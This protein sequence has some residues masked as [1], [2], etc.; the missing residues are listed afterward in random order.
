MVTIFPKKIKFIK[1]IV[2]LLVRFISSSC[3]FFKIKF[4]FHLFLCPYSDV[5]NKSDCVVYIINYVSSLSSLIYQM[6]LAYIPVYI[7]RPPK[8]LRRYCNISVTKLSGYKA[9]DVMDYY[10]FLYILGARINDQY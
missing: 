2:Y 1:S 10:Y 4:M 8:L 7:A 5:N 3:I 6:T 9:V